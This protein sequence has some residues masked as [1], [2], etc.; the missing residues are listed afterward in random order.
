M[1]SNQTYEVIKQRILDNINI[2]IDK[3]EGSFLSNM[4]APLVEELAKA[5]KFPK[6]WYLHLGTGSKCKFSDLPPKG[7][8]Q[9]SGFSNT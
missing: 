5:F 8:N 1:F 3:R 7:L 2:D 4:V 9:P 6:L